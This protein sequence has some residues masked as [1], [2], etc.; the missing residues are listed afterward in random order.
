MPVSSTSYSGAVVTLAGRRIDPEPTLTPRF[1]FDQVDRVRIGITDQL[2]CSHA[3]GF[4]SVPTAAFM[5]IAE[6][7]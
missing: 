6:T 1:P 2:R 4:P 7:E 5:Y 3:V